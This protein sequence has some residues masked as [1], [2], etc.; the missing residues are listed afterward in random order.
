MKKTMIGAGIVVEDFICGF[1]AVETR[2][3]HVRGKS[4][5]SQEF[6]DN[7]HHMIHIPLLLK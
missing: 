2:H 7:W 3:P 1:K 4:V 5:Y 6:V